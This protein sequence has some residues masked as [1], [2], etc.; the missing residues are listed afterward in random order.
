MAQGSTHAFPCRPA[1][2]DLEETLSALRTLQGQV[3][4]SN[5][6]LI[7]GGGPVGVEFAGEVFS[8]YPGKKITLVTSSKTLIASANN[9]K[10]H[11]KLL[12]QLEKAGVRVIFGQKVSMEDD[13]TRPLPGLTKFTTNSGEEIEADFVF[14]GF[15]SRPNTDLIKQIDGD[16]VNADGFV[17]VNDDLTIKS[18]VVPHLYAV[19]DVNELPGGKT[20]MAATGQAPVAAANILVNVTDIGKK[21]KVSPPRAVMAIPLGAKGGAIQLPFATLGE[22]TVSLIKGRTLFV[23]SFTSMYK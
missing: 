17:K 5:S 16:A 13:S 8:Q 1:S 15:G 21:Q 11:S 10:L 18:S 7:S 12:Y 23:S 4:K 22:W 2:S 19:G 3:E 9:P 6:I 20:Y 14:N